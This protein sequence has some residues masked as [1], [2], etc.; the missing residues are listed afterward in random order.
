MATADFR[1]AAA[2]VASVRGDMAG[3]IVAHTAA[4]EA[5]AAHGVS[6]LIFPELSLTGYEPDLA[7]ELATTATDGRLVPL[8]TLARQHR[9][10]V[11]VGAPL[12]NAT[13]KPN[14]CAILFAADG[15]TRTYSKMRLGA[16]ERA[17]FTP[18]G[19]PLAFTV[20]GHTIGIAICGDSSQPSHPRG[21]ADAGSSIYA[22]GVFLNA[23]WY[24]TDSPRLAG[25]ATDCRMLV[26]MANHA[27]SVGTYRSVGRSAVWAPGGALLA[28]AAGAESCLVIATSSRGAWRGEVVRV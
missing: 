4:I 18:G 22:A 3:N 6:V 17:Y 27:D 14:L 10:E 2:Q 23:E 28:Q 12:R 26:V 21:Y 19:E 20:H 5:A 11:A 24:A 25:Y 7:A 9:I 16:S 1:I 15:T 13:A 8:A